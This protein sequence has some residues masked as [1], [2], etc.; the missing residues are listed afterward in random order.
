MDDIQDSVLTPT[1]LK[2]LEIKKF[3]LLLNYSTFTPNISS[4]NQADPQHALDI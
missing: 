2:K 3:N 4:N 1:E